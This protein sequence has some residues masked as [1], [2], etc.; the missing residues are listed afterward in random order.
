MEKKFPT[1]PTPP[2]IANRTPSH[3]NSKFVQIKISSFVIAPQ[4]ED[5][6]FGNGIL[7]RESVFELKCRASLLMRF[8][9]KFILFE[10]LLKEGL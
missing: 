9:S 7:M 4:L 10:N 8:Q 1:S 6:L 3:Q 5:S 2:T